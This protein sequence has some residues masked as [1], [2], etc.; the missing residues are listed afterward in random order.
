MIYFCKWS[1]ERRRE[2]GWL[3]ERQVVSKFAQRG[4]I[5]SILRL[6]FP[7]SGVWR[8]KINSDPNHLNQQHRA[9]LTVHNKGLP[10]CISGVTILPFSNLESE[11]NIG[12]DLVQ[13]EQATNLSDSTPPT[14]T[15]EMSRRVNPKLRI[16]N[17]PHVKSLKKLK[18]KLVRCRVSHG[19]EQVCRAVVSKKL[20]LVLELESEPQVDN[21]AS[22]TCEVNEKVHSETCAVSDATW[23]GNM[24]AGSITGKDQRKARYEEKLTTSSD[25]DEI[26]QLLERG[27]VSNFL[28]SDLRDR[29]DQLVMSHVQIQASQEDEELEEDSQ[30]RMGQLMLSYFQRHSHPA[31]SQE[32]EQVHEHEQEHEQ[33]QTQELDGR[34]HGITV[35]MLMFV[36]RL[37]LHLC[38]YLFQTQASNQDRRYSSSISHSSLEMEFVYDFKRPYGATLSVKCMNSENQFRPA[39]EMQTNLQNSLKA[40]EVHPVQ[41]N[42]KDS[43]D[44]RP[45]KR[46]CCICYEKPGR[47]FSVQNADAE[48]CRHH[49]GLVGA[50]CPPVNLESKTNG[51]KPPSPSLSLGSRLASYSLMRQTM[52][53]N[54]HLIFYFFLVTVSLEFDVSFQ[55]NSIELSI[56]KL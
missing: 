28:A 33:E 38:T 34:S 26:R 46:S 42:G 29:I 40:Q 35:M 1:K 45:N 5:Q 24:P 56:I 14:S 23:Q 43:P 52:C 44:R 15:T 12:R 13:E 30:E 55:R 53:A 41:G 19:K 11:F 51:T 36:N 2:L 7:A 49:Y 3:G 6:R 21:S 9:I 37:K 48:R 39:W 50:L 20:L 54:L 31:G 22:A 25:N 47:L 16:Q 27:T 10:S 4:R 32:E 18:K 17:Q 8:L